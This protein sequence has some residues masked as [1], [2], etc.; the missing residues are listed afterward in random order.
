MK[1]YCV[2]GG[3]GFIGTHLCKKLISEGHRV[4]NVDNFSDFYDYKLK[5]ANVLYSS[6]ITI[7]F[8]F[9]TKEND[10]SIL[11]SYVNGQKYRLIIGDIRSLIDLELVFQ[12]E[13]IDAVIHLAGMAGVRPSIEEPQ[14]YEEVNIRG[15]LNLLETMRKY[16]V[17][18]WLCASSSSVYGNP[19]NRTFSESDVVDLTLS[20]YAATKKACE[21]LG[22]VYYH[23]HG[24]DTIMLRFFTVYGPRQRPDLAI[25][26]FTRLIHSGEPLSFFGEGNSTRDYTYVDDTVMGII[27]AL[28]YLQEHKSIY[29]IVNLGKG[30]SITLQYMVQSIERALG[31]KARIQKLPMQPGDV[32]H[33]CANISKARRLIGYN[34]QTDFIAGMNKFITWY[35]GESH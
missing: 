30:Q 27:K 18:K 5:I 28:H 23:L 31:T 34:P 7:P 35:R 8:P 26:K 9:T 33:T 24:I 15:T 2:T 29:E 19:S 10:L 4:I 12:S 13:R 21:V 14:L 32:E 17:R 11:P 20:P 22:Y 25:T 1:T 16:K 6:G 3:A